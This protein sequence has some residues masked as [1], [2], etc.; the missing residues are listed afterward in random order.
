MAKEFRTFEELVKLMESR[1]I[2]TDEDTIPVL[3]RESYY[4]VI[5]GYKDPF[6]DREAMKASADDVYLPG[7]TF[8]RIYD[9]FLFDRNLRQSVFQYLTSAEAVMKNAVVYAFCDRNRDPDAYLERSNYCTAS[10][11]LVPK[12]YRGNKAGEFSTNAPRSRARGS[13]RCSTCFA[14]YCRNTKRRP[15]SMSSIP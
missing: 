14:W 4:A 12:S 9:L 15:W 11:M 7:T 5:N 8:K 6:L 13:R 3:K 10:D 2:E 1:G